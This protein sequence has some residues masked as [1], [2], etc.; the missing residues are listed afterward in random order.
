MRM[1]FCILMVVGMFV[2]CGDTSEPDKGHSS[3]NPLTAPV[4]YLGAVNQGKNK[5]LGDAGL[6]QV[7]NALKQF[8]AA[9]SRR[10]KNLQEVIAAGYLTRMPDLPRGMKWQY[11]PQTGQASSV[12]AR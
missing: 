12:P 9:H 8:E 2:G 11:N 1:T 5:V 4:D 3:G 7:N 6:F 10:A